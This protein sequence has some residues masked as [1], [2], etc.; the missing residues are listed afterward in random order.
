MPLHDGDVIR[1]IPLS[2]K[3]ENAIVLRGNVAVPGRYPY[4]DG[5][6][7]RDLIPNRE[8]LLTPDFWKAQIAVKERS[9]Y[10]RTT[11]SST[12]TMTLSEYRHFAGRQ[13]CQSG[14]RGAALDRRCRKST[15]PKTRVPTTGISIRL[16][17]P[18]I[19]WDYAVVQRI[20]PGR[21]DDPSGEF[22][23]W[24]SARRRRFAEY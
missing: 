19:N 22:Q 17:A 8:F 13:G 11:S 10:S 18:E 9:P 2:P 12:S 6:R 7:I 23:P 3:I 4:H 20:N 16:S 14:R 21:P 15:S 1:V 5:M 24:Q